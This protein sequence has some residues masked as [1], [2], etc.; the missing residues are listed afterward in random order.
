MN[1]NPLGFLPPLP[2]LEKFK[3]QNH[4]ALRNIFGKLIKGTFL[5]E[6]LCYIEQKYINEIAQFYD[7]RFS[8][9]KMIV[10]MDNHL[11]DICRLIVGCHRSYTIFMPEA[12][13]LALERS[14]EYKDKLALNVCQHIKVRR[15]GS[16]YFRNL[17][18]M[19]G[20]PFLSYNLPYDI[21]ALAVRMNEVLHS[22][23][24]AEVPLYEI[25]SNKALAALSLLE[26]NFLS[27]C[28]PIC[29]AIIELYLKLVCFKMH[30]TL[31]EEYEKFNGFEVLQS[32]CTQEYPEAFNE[33]YTNRAYQGKT[34]KVDYL[35]YGWVDSIPDY[36]TIVT[37]LP[38]SMNGL[39]RYL[40]EVSGE[41]QWLL[42]M[43]ESFHKMCHGYTH[44][45]VNY[46]RY[47][48]LQ[49]FEVS[50]ILFY[51]V[52]SSYYYLFESLGLD[53]AINGVD[54]LQKANADYE[55][56]IEQYN[57]RSTEL[58]EKHYGN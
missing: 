10:G 46:V 30:P 42:D 1:Q 6:M 34:K 47:P 57:R 12:E 21:L 39:F 32:C 22:N 28:Y 8:Q 50:L 33:L 52:T 24:V 43:L 20:E 4:K 18:M 53:P 7:W 9:E 38:Y 11:Y 25:I 19:Q 5:I 48:V 54:I 37:N 45:N 36:H 35:H 14:A 27:N 58:F 49:Y 26:D 3:K 23:T 41:D 29:R 16:V 13:R 55:V 44:G 31:K 15:Y 56:L 40:R 17:P 2:D 51:T